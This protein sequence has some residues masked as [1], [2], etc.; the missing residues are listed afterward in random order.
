LFALLPATTGSQTGDFLVARA[1]D[2][3]TW[4]VNKYGHNN[5]TTLAYAHAVGAGL[6]ANF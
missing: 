1:K 6:L 4:V 2:I 3:V 5:A